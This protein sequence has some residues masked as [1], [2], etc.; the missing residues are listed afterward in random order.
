VAVAVGPTSGK[1]DTVTVARSAPV[2]KKSGQGRAEL[3]LAAGELVFASKGYHGATMREV[4]DAAGVGLSL[5]V[6]HFKTKDG[7][8]RAIFEARQYVNDER[9]ARLAAV[10]DAEAPDALQRVVSAFIDPVLA[11]HDDPADVWFARLVLREASDP[12]SQER[13]VIAELFDPMAR[14]FVAK[15]EEV[16]PGRPAGFHAWAYLFSVGALTQSAFDARIDNL[17]GTQASGRKHEY[18]RSYITAALRHA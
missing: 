18:L 11:L 6:Y 7:L 5:V 15:L 16:L 2:A 10:T 8:Y 1:E 12:S 17:A 3:I 13:T 9:V 4:A 14:A